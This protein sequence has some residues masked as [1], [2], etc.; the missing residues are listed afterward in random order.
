M[1]TLPLSP[2]KVGLKS[3]F[4]VFVEE[5][6]GLGLHDKFY[7]NVFIVSAL[8]GQRPQFWA[9]FGGSCVDRLLPMR[10]KSGV[11]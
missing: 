2:P 10:A 5:V 8:G 9:N 4:A 11:L 7:L 1:R 6:E 3:E